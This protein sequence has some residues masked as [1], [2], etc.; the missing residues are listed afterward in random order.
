MFGKSFILLA[1]ASLAQ[2]KLSDEADKNL[3]TLIDNT[4][5][6]TIVWDR[7]AQMTDTYGHRLVG[8]E[9]LEKSIDWIVKLIKK[10]GIKVYTEPVKVSYWRREHESLKLL[11]KT[12][13][14]VNLKVNA[15]GN[16]VSTPR[17]GITADVVPV[18]GW[19]E[20]DQLLAKDPNAV[21]DKIVLYNFPFTTYGNGTSYRNKGAKKAEDNGAV[22][23]MIRSVA[24]FGL[25]NNHVGFQTSPS[26]IPSVAITYEDAHLID[27]MY[28]RATKQIE[29]EVLSKKQ[30]QFPRVHLDIRTKFDNLTHTSRNIIAEIP[31][32]EYPDEYVVFGG[33]SD[34]WDLG[35]GA[36]DDGAGSFTA[37]EALRQISKLPLKPKRTIQAV[38][39]TS[40]ENGGIGGIQFAKNREHLFDKMAFVMETDFNSGRPDGIS[41]TGNEKQEK[42]LKDTAETYLKPHGFGYT[43]GKGYDGTDIDP[44][45]EEGKVPCAGFDSSVPVKNTYYNTT[46]GENNED[47]PGGYFWYHHTDADRME[48]IK[49]EQLA[50][51]SATMAAYV[52]AIAQNDEALHKMH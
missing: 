44:I 45:C 4:L 14:K 48:A 24:S 40:E 41:F 17:G 15:L 21:K 2:G 33:H 9:G 3:K 47:I 30:V 37:Y 52:Y 39:W 19:Y 12:R 27:R 25:N 43:V 6:T 23:S 20:L 49:P 26:T 38:F 16:T 34:S 32:T 42:F 8:S 31:G 18:S 36:L 50:Q 22:A 1:L 7:L 13:G 11:T 51:C 46:L 5:N 28:K 35:V 10:D 29:T